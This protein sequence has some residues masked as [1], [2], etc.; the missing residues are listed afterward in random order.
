MAN[1]H[2]GPEVIER[3]E[4]GN[5][6]RDVKAATM[7]LIGTAP[8]HTVHSTP[9]AR[10]NYIETD[11]VIRRKEDAV[12]AF[13]AFSEGEGYS[14]PSALHSIFNKDRG[15]GVGTLIVRNVFDP[16]VHKEDTT[17]DPTKVT[18]ADIVGELTVAGKP[19][20]LEAAMY[21]YGKFGYFPRRIIAPRF[22]TTLSVRQ[23][24]LTVANKV[25]GHAITDLPPGLTKQGIVEKR[26]VS[27]EYQ[28][29]D[30][31]LVYCAPHVM[32]L[33]AVTADQSLQ[34]LSQHFG[35]VWNEVVNREEGDD[36]G[37]PAASPSNRSMPDVSALEIPLYSYPGDTSSDGN[38]INEAG[39]V[40]ADMGEFGAG[41]KTWGA[42]ASSFGATSASQV[43]KWL[44]VRAMYDVL[45]EAILWHLVPYIDKRGTPQRVE[46]LED[47]IQRYVNTKE[48]DNWLYGGRFSFDRKKNTAEEILGQGRFWYRLDGAPMAIM[49]RISVES[50]I[51]LNLVRSALGLGGAA[52]A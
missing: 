47:Q 50:Y 34:P 26:G 10:A 16:D 32:A 22:S 46:F 25:R 31:R 9:E 30:D 49:H 38:F 8:I 37:G 7:Y 39:I 40:T 14:I 20:G 17:P 6:V 28:L 3:F 2:H 21:T 42:H 5:V 48:R 43:T 41:I 51:D 23:K 29:G 19:K 36:D 4:G 35:G 27:Q 24:M 15:R 52:S 12:A 1:Y 45:H 44:H 11:I 13:G 18:P 33:D